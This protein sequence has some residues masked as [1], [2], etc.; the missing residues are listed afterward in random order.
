MSFERLR[1]E[2]IATS[3]VQLRTGDPGS[4]EFEDAVVLRSFGD[5]P[6]DLNTL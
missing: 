5:V 4:G 3:I 1:C 6:D 2:E